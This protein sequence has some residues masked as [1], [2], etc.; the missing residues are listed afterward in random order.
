MSERAGGFDLHHSDESDREAHHAR[1]AH[2]QPEHPRQEFRA[3]L[4]QDLKKMVKESSQAQD[5]SV[6]ACLV[7]EQEYKR[8]EE[9]A[10]VEVVVVQQHGLVVVHCRQHARSED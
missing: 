5:T 1:D 8:H 9:D 6:I 10:G 2:S 7:L 3:T 4:G